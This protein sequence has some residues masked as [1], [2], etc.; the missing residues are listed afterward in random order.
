ML[1]LSELHVI[2]LKV[3]LSGVWTADKKYGRDIMSIRAV[4]RR[5]RKTELLPLRADGKGLLSWYSAAALC[6][7]HGAI[8]FAVPLCPEDEALL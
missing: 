4:K 8:S 7:Q 2:D 6:K 3:K 5:Q 1:H